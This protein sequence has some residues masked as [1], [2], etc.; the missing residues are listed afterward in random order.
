MPVEKEE[1][2]SQPIHIAT[3]LIALKSRHHLSNQCIEDILSLLRLFSDK[4][5]SSC[6][7]LCTLLRKRSTTHVRPETSTICPHCEQVSSKLNTCSMCGANYSPIPISIVPLFYTYDIALQ[8]EAILS[9]SLDLLLTD[10]LSSRKEMSDIKDGDVYQKL[11][12]TESERFITLIM[13]I[14]GVLPNKGSDQSLWPVLLV[15]NEIDRRKRFSLENLIIG[16]MCPGPSKPARSQMSLFLEKIVVQLKALES[17]RTFHVYSTSEEIQTQLIKVCLLASC[18][19]K[20]A[21]CLIQC[22]PE[23]TA[24]FGCGACELEG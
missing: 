14:D 20:T 24:F 11:I 18:C 5:P 22:L 1:I 12:A 3:A 4:I 15:I 13:N 8:L 7:S 23:P 19:D 21:Q 2:E 10:N 6:K 17:G 16:G 9:S